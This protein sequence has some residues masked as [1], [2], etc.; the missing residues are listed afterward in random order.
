MSIDHAN[1]TQLVR[2]KVFQQSFGHGVHMHTAD[3]VLIQDCYFSGTL[4]PT[5]DIYKEKA[6]RA[7]ENHFNMLFRSKQPIPRDRMI[8]LTEDGLR[9][10]EDVKNVKVVNTII[11]RFRG[12][13]Q[14]L[15]TGDVE[16]DGVTVIEPGDFGFDVSAV[17]GS[18]IVMKNCRSDVAY[19]PVLNLTRGD[20][21]E[22]AEYELTLLSPEGV[23]FTSQS[24]LGVICGKKCTFIFR[25]TLKRPLPE[26]V[27]VVICGGKQEL[28]DSTVENHTTAKLVLEA[29]V[30][31]CDIR[32]VGPVE[33]K[34]KG[35]RIVKLEKEP[36]NRK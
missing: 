17:K 32:S 14:L 9:T 36:G 19:N 4:R 33:D 29:N 2:C 7:V 8:P 16:L 25:D 24:G 3:G 35:N 31:N 30:R 26:E 27:N 22:N 11:E 6:G 1:G 13:V 12:A 5:N 23:A 10:Y 20:L 34:G 18:K 21:P 28:T 15:C